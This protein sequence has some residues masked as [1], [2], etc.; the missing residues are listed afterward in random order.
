MICK[1]IQKGTRYLKN[2]LAFPR[3]GLL[4]IIGWSHLGPSHLIRY[5]SKTP[6]KVS[7]KT[8]SFA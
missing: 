3:R 6:F 7:F 5:P 4:A 8:A 2:E 1:E